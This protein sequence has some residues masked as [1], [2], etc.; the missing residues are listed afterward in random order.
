MELEEKME[1]GD[2]GVDPN[3]EVD[4]NWG[5]EPKYTVTAIIILYVI[6]I[7]VNNFF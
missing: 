3:G 7:I 5:G 4:P 1:G 6:A 2:G